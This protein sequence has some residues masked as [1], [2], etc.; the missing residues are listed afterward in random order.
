MIQGVAF[1]LF[2]TLLTITHEVNPFR[3]LLQEMRKMKGPSEE[4]VGLAKNALTQDF[5]DVDGFCGYLIEKGVPKVIANRIAKE[6]RQQ[7]DSAKLFPETLEVLESIRASARKIAIVSNL[8]SP[9]GMVVDQFKLRDLVDAVVFSYSAGCRKPDLQIYRTAS[10]ALG[11]PIADMLMVGDTP[12]S[13][14]H[15]AIRAG[16]Q[17]VFLDRAGQSN[18]SP[19]VNDLRGVLTF[20]N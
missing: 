5:G 15:G 4:I 11:I 3:T 12:V 17:A 18:L 7:I 9:F 16:A 20:L 10:E 1:D 14:F 13:D 19:R 2:G 6:T 8:G